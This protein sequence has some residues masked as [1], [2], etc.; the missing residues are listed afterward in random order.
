MLRD[1]ALSATVA[2]QDLVAFEHY[3]VHSIVNP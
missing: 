1:H 3:D 2:V